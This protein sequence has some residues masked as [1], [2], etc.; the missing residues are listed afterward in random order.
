M[1]QPLAPFSCTYSS[2]VPEI[3]AYLGCSLV[4]STYQAGKVILLSP[5]EDG[6]IQLARNFRKPMGLALR[7]GRMAVATEFTVEVLENAPTMARGYPPKPHTYDALFL[8][9]VTFHTGTLDL[10]DLVWVGEDLWGVNT[11]FSCLCR[12]SARYSFE[13]V[14]RPPFVSALMPED[15]CHLNG[16]AFEDGH[17]R[18]VTA[19][20]RTD[21]PRGW[22]ENRYAGGVLVDVASGE[23]LLDGLAMPH[24]P[25]IIDGDLYFLTSA[26]GALCRADPEAGRYEVVTRVPGFARGLARLGPYLF[27]GHSRIR[28]KHLF[29]DLPLAEREH[30]AGVV[31]VHLE[32]GR[33]AGGIRYHASCE[34]IYDVQVFPGSLRPGIVGVEGTV[35][36]QAVHAPGAGFWAIEKTASDPPAPNS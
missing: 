18:F 19:L 28:K 27:V 13:P 12:V 20:G 30:V 26:D 2:E 22:Q 14:W 36:Q 6:L 7:E 4:L 21:T 10:H 29:G 24:S 9:R 1:K 34:E 11:L 17:P 33:V 16:V 15:R 8:P 23:V 5:R 3:L 31:I 25:R 35:H 32:S